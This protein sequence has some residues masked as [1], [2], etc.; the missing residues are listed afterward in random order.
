MNTSSDRQR[1]VELLRELHLPAARE[2]FAQK[3]QE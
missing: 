1:L 3:A 2:C